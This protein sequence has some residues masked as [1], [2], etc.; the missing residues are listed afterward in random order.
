VR[1]D[2]PL[3]FLAAQ[4]THAAGESSPGNLN[5]GTYAVVLAVHDE[6]SLY[7]LQRQLQRAGVPHVS[8]T[9]PDP[10]WNG[11]LTA[12]G[13]VPTTD[14]RLLKSVLGSL[15]LLGRKDKVAA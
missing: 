12:I 15:P 10:P 13:I 5:Q 4:I 2:L 8:I 7:L 11:A 9:E 1:D 14:R 6:A 3:G